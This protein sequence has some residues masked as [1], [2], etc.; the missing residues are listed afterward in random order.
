MFSVH[1]LQTDESVSKPWWAS[2]WNT[3]G[4]RRR[5]AQHS[6]GGINFQ[7][8][9]SGEAAQFAQRRMKYV[10]SRTSQLGAVT[11]LKIHF[12]PEEWNIRNALFF[13][14]VTQNTRLKKKKITTRQAGFRCILHHQSSPR[15]VKLNYYKC[16]TWSD[17]IIYIYF[18]HIFVYIQCRSIYFTHLYIGSV[19]WF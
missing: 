15:R 11:P 18:R 1:N 4:F 10:C 19:T 2:S 5:E 8:R 6:F 7:K 9:R 12:T 3:R 17:I 16:A 13:F 14:E